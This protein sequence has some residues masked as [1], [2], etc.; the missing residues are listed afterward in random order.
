MVLQC[1]RQDNGSAH[2][3]CFCHNTDTLNH[4]CVSKAWLVESL[5]EFLIVHCVGG[6]MIWQIVVPR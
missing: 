6:L 5:L 2:M 1:V 4:Q 3:S